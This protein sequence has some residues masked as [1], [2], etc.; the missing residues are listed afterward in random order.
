MTNR[1]ITTTIFFMAAWFAGA[2][3]LPAVPQGHAD[4]SAALAARNS[5]DVGALRH[6]INDAQ[7]R[8]EQE[9]T[10]QAYQTLAQ[11]ELWLCEIGHVRNDDKL[12]KQAAQ[13]GVSAAEKAIAIDPNSSEAHRL[14]G[15]SL[16][17][18]IRHVFAGGPRYGP[19]STREIDR[20]IELDAR[21]ANAYIARAYN[22][23]FTPKA[24]GGDKQ[25]AVEMLKKALELDSQSDTAHLWLAQVYL[26][27]GQKQDALSEINT[28]LRL[29]PHRA[30]TQ[31]VYRQ[32]ENSDHS[33]A[34][35]SASNK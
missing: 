29:D 25:K 16:S 5:S 35:Q 17:Q 9:K 32:M 18:L 2:A 21:N 19:R 4:M 1:S 6:L 10:A 24:F 27:L 15:E 3:P 12:V 13:D 7:R 34:R 31:Q 8:A 11:L 22:Y 28:A 33:A 14:E 20:A 26:A 23:F 30:F